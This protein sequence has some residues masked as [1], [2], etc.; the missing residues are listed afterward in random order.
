MEFGLEKINDI[1]ELPNTNMEEFEVKVCEPGSCMEKRICL[2]KEVP[3]ASTKINISMNDFTSEAWVWLT[4]LFIQV[5]PFTR[6]ITILD[7]QVRMVF[8]IL[9][10]INL[11]IGRLVISDISFYRNYGG[12]HLIFP[13]LSTKLCRR[14][15]VMEY[16]AD[17]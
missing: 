1:Y 5:S 7:L 3:W 9:D 17:T 10:G 6:K 8:C 13:Y 16:P 15:G 2:V 14:P 11:N 4:I 12:T